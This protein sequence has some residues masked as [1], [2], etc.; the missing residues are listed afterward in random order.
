MLEIS[1][2]TFSGDNSFAI[3]ARGDCNG[4]SSFT[5]ILDSGGESFEDDDGSFIASGGSS[6]RFK[7]RGIFEDFNFG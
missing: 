4:I 7:S 3:L 2:D 1:D 6:V 5:I